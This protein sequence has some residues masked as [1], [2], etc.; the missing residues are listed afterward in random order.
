M[1]AA[2][3]GAGAN[4]HRGDARRGALR[5]GPMARGGTTTVARGGAERGARAGRAGAQR[6][7]RG[8]PKAPRRQDMSDLAPE[9]RLAIVWSCPFAQRG[10]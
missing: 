3:G 4:G 7:A 1:A 2:R 5:G 6:G 8:T 10:C 9:E